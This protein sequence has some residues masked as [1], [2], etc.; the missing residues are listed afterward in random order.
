MKERANV[1][2]MLILLG[3]TIIHQLARLL[4]G[5]KTSQLCS[6]DRETALANVCPACADASKA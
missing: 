3:S 1:Y 4:A 2:G 6:E 5:P